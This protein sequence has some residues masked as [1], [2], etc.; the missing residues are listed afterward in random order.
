MRVRVRVGAVWVR[1]R[2][3]R[4]RVHWATKKEKHVCNWDSIII[5]IVM[6]IIIK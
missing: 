2:V 6:I 4:W 5:I 1:V 3:R